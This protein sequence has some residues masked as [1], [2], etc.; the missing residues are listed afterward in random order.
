MILRP[1]Y[2]DESDHGP[3]LGMTLHDVIYAPPRPM[4]N[5][6]YRIFCSCS[7]EKVDNQQGSNPSH[8]AAES[9]RDRIFQSRLKQILC[10]LLVIIDYVDL[11]HFW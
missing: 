4:L 8:S 9:T 5:K 6:A 2:S 1:P 3:A 7:C 10:S 11:I